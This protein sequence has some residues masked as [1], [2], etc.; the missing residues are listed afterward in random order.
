MK[1]WIIAVAFVAFCHYPLFAQSASRLASPSAIPLS[2]PLGLPPSLPQFAL[3]QIIGDET[4]HVDF[5]RAE[6]NSASRAA[7]PVRLADHFDTPA[8]KASAHGRSTTTELQSYEAQVPYVVK[9]K[10]QYTVQVP[11]Q[12]EITDDDGRQR[13]VT[14]T[15]SEIRHR[16]VSTTLMRTEKRT[17]TAVVHSDGSTTR[18]ASESQTSK[19]FA[20]TQWKP[21]P[22]SMAL[23]L[24]DIVFS[25]PRGEAVPANVAAK[26]LLVRQ[27]VVF[28]DNDDRLSPYFQQLVCP[29]TLVVRRK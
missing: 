2:L 8:S 14:R 16:I 10:Q 9:K 18:S 19:S 12:Q 4:V 13:S 5:V 20:K 15:R 3:A 29:E 7:V 11:Y 21:A 17:R 28:L 26:Q 6:A 25:S 22:H 1:R 24:A 23:N 27:P